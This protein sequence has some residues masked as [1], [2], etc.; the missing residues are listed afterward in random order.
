MRN[1]LDNVLRH[2]I[3]LPTQ[4]GGKHDMNIWYYGI[5]ATMHCVDVVGI[6]GTLVLFIGKV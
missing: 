6:I 2:G 5:N 3:D 1:I 4:H